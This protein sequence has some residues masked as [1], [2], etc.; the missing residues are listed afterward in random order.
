M[1]PA[2]A[3]GVL[4]ADMSA[5]S[6]LPSIT[7]GLAESRDYAL[8]SQA[9]GLKI[10]DLSA[11]VYWGKEG[12][13]ALLAAFAKPFTPEKL[14][15]APFFSCKKSSV[16]GVTLYHVK[17]L[18]K[19]KSAQKVAKQDLSC[20]VALL[21]GNTAA[22]FPDSDSAVNS[23]AQMKGKSGFSFSE[24]MKGTLRG[25]AKID[26]PPFLEAS[27]NCS[28]GGKDKG[29][30]KGVL[31]IKTPSPEEAKAANAQA[32][33]LFTM[34]VL[35]SMQEE[36]ELGTRLVKAFKFRASGSNVTVT[37]NLSAALL[38]DLSAFAA[39]EAEKRKAA[40]KSRKA[41]KKSSAP[42]KQTGTSAR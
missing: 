10:S 3:E 32:K 22:F 37:A 18:K 41:R 9:S 12:N 15:T 31:T 4:S 34:F 20:W 17:S 27:L 38:N 35:Q 2:G 29:G 7:K 23:L 28:A 21:P 16:S 11:L 1:V 42:N 25:W 5:L 40:K 30:F 13:M 8:W 26:Q 39:K 36:E 14:F 33:M 19:I 6:Q 24:G